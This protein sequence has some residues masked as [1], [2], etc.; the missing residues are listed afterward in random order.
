MLPGGRLRKGAHTVG[1]AK[2]DWLSC[3]N[4]LGAD[5]AGGVRSKGKARRFLYWNGKEVKGWTNGSFR[6]RK[7][8]VRTAFFFLLLLVGLG[9]GVWWALREKDHRYDREIAEIARSNGLPPSLV[10]ALVWRESRFQ[11]GARGTR[12]EIGLMQLQPTTAQAWADANHNRAFEPEH[13]TNPATN[14]QAGC[15]HLAMIVRRYSKTDSPWTYALADYNAGRGNVL[16][17]LTGEAQTNS[18]A[19]MAAMTFPGTRSYVREILERAPRYASD[20]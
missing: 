18:A 17:W 6:G 16:R 14:L 11:A 9:T 2:Y 7:A 3:S 8:V 12:D 20:F 10:K 1:P 5:R 19:F 4:A 15:F 13:L